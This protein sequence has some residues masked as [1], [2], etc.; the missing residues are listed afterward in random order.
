MQAS[1]NANL[2]GEFSLNKPKA[3]DIAQW[4]KKRRLSLQTKSDIITSK[5]VRRKVPHG[6]EKFERI[7]VNLL[8]SKR[9]KTNLSSSDSRLFD[10]IHSHKIEGKDMFK[11]GIWVPPEASTIS[12]PLSRKNLY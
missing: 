3:Q 8:K 5:N 12:G 11:A 2:I 7:K 4:F 9:Q 6:E 1:R 10:G